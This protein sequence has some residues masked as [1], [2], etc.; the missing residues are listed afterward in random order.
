MK[1]FY[2]K[3][4]N[5][6]L[7]FG[8][9][10]NP[11]LWENLIPGALDSDEKVAFVGIGSLIN[12][13]LP[14]KIRHATK[15]VIFGSGVGYGNGN[16]KLDDSYTVYCVRGPLSAKA[17][18]L[19]TEAGITDGAALI[20]RVYKN[21]AKKKYRFAYMP[22][23]ELAGE[24]W[25]LACKQSGFGYVDPRWPL[26]KVL[27]AMGETEVLLAEAMHGAIIADALRIPWIPIVTN[28]SILSFKWQDW[29]ASIQVEYKPVHIERLF[30]P[31]EKKDVFT[32]VRVVRDRLRQ[33]KASKALQQTAA[34]QSPCLSQD[35]VIERLTE[36][37][38][39]KLH[40]FQQDIKRGKFAC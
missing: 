20:R 12:D 13:A 38:E 22:H 3:L 2:F 29:C 14:Q 7:N 11:W 6:E 10:L 9:N 8:D 24:G 21:T 40:Q 19:P 31:R 17:L 32:P 15:R 16:L 27:S 39:E 34:T 25:E 26:E 30:H 35:A 4:P 36:R 5:G 23:Y 37:L 28:S 18:G 33:Q 1:L